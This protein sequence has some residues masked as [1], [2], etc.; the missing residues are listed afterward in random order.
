V[1]LA[2]GWWRDQALRGTLKV[3]QKSTER[4]LSSDEWLR[5]VS[6]DRSQDGTEA[7]LSRHR[8]EVQQLLGR[9]GAHVWFADGVHEAGCLAHL[10]PPQGGASAVRGSMMFAISVIESAGNPPRRACSATVSGS[11]AS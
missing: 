8:N 7:G 3:D 4:T 6:E 2:A 1:L 11:G 5:R 10:R 9:N